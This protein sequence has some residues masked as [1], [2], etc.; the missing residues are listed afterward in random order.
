[1]C[2][3]A[4]IFSGSRPAWRSWLFRPHL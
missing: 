3:S 4:R 1:V 2:S